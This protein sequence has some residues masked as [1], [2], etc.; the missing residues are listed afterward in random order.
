MVFKGELRAT[1]SSV[2]RKFYQY[3]MKIHLRIHNSMEKYQITPR[4]LSVSKKQR[5]LHEEAGYTK[6][7]PEFHFKRL[8]SGVK[9]PGAR[10]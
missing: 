8:A 6:T 4:A 3:L 2:S 1:S 5:N 9:S 10:R 7:T